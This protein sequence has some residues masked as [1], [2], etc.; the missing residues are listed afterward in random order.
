MPNNYLKM[1]VPN[2]FVVHDLSQ[3][4]HIMVSILYKGLLNKT[5][6]LKVVK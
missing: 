3:V 4:I 6:F 1:H 2:K 5:V